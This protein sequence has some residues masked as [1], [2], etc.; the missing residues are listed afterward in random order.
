[1]N[2][3]KL[4]QQ[5]FQASTP[6]CSVI[7]ILSFFLNQMFNHEI[8]L[9]LRFPIISNIAKAIKASIDQFTSSQ[10]K[11]DQILL[12]FHEQHAYGAFK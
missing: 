9:Y 3:N 2:Y 10:K 12:C 4:R 5:E 7:V 8:C 11:V 6:L 1:M